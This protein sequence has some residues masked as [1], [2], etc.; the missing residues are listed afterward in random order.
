MEPFRRGHAGD[1]FTYRLSAIGIGNGSQ[2]RAIDLGPPNYQNI[3]VVGDTI[4]WN[5][6]FANVDLVVR[7]IH[8]LKV[9]VVIKR[10]SC[11]ICGG[12]KGKPDEKMDF[13]TARFEIPDHRHQSGRQTGT[14]CRS[15]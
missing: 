12:P 9:D 14:T 5:D 7:Y 3:S 10:N 11:V 2:F 6:I 8:I 1:T 4:R 13:L 15:L